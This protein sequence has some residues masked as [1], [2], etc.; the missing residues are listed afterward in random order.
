[1]VIDCRA[2]WY[3]TVGTTPVGLKITLYQGGVINKVGF[4]YEN[5][6]A[7]ASTILNLTLKNI[8]LYSQ[9]PT[10]VGERIATINYNI[11]TGVGSVNSSNV[12]VYP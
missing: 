9:T 10:S 3:G 12:T 5:P 11:L 2:Q 4:G 6:T 8:T 7:T 1:M